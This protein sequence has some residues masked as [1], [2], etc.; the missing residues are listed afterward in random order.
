MISKKRLVRWNQ[1]N[2]GLFLPE[3]LEK[4]SEV[5]NDHATSDSLKVEGFVS[6]RKIPVDCP[7]KA[8]L[9]DLG[10]GP[11]G[12][13]LIT[14]TG[15]AALCRLA[16]DVAAGGGGGALY[17]LGYL[18][19]GDGS[20]S[21]ALVPNAASTELY[22]ELTGTTPVRPMCSLTTPGSAPLVTLILTAQ[23]GY[24]ELNG[25]SIDESAIFCLDN[26]TM[27]SF[28]TFTAQQKDVYFVFEW[29]WTIV[30]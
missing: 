7:E 28:K 20:G 29:R 13:N 26:S 27:F 18:A 2:K 17:S 1:S 14:D 5:Y 22:S 10:T 12:K 30:F 25:T 3:E 11:V 9:A 19:V 16:R 23:I 4:L 6:I 15:R 21:G 24:S 8:E